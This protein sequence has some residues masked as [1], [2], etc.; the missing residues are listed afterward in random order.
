MTN[1]QDDFIRTRNKTDQYMPEVE[2]R[3]V[4]R[5]LVGTWLFGLL[6]RYE[7]K[8]TDWSDK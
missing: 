2:H 5:V 1:Y 4:E 7:Y 3:Q 8:Y 6:K